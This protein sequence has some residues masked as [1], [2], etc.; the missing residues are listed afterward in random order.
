[1]KQPEA[2]RAIRSETQQMDTKQYDYIIVGAG[3]AGCV[4]A[5]RLSADARTRVLLLE[6]GPPDSKL[7]I[8]IPAGMTRL[9]SDPGVNWRY[10][11]SSE[12]GLNGRMLACPRGKT[13]GGSS[14]INGL[15]YMRG[16]PDDYNHWRELGNAGWGWDDVLPFYRRSECYEGGSTAYHGADGELSVENLKAPHIAS[17]AFVEAGQRI[18]VP[19]NTD[20][21]GA[22]HEGIG[23]LQL[24]LRQG[25]RE[26]AS[27]AFLTPAKHRPN[28]DVQVN[29]H[30]LKV[31]TEGRVATG[32]VYRQGGVEQRALA[33]EVILSG[34]AI[35]SPQL[36]M[37]SGIGPAQQLRGFGID[38][39]HDL[40]GVG[41]NLH[42]HTYVHY[43]AEVSPEFSINRKISSNLRV[44][45]HV[46]RYVLT[47]SGLL[48][49]AAAQVGAYL[50]SRPGLTR[51]DLQLQFRP[52]SILVRKDGR[53]TAENVPAV[54]ASCSQSRPKSRGRL[55]LAAAD[56]FAPPQILF[57]YLTDSEDCRV[58]MSGV[59]W[60]RRMFA[61]SP[62]V[63]HVVKETVPGGGVDSDDELLAYLRANAQPMYHPVGS[64]KMGRDGMS[65]VDE[66]LRVHGIERLRVVDASVMPAITS[67]NTNAPTI[68]IAE[69]ASQMILE[70]AHG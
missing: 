47:R 27:S 7:W 25:V 12:P 37:L 69:K 14:S 45:P 18:G 64:C 36:L 5:N 59:R 35:N 34:G 3:S 53:I 6:A 9:I 54:T 49:S 66:R 42:D 17:R 16:H 44:L 68:M 52:F 67:G 57:N 51:P 60:M 65:V 46:L 70:D 13:L 23:F 50:R 28:L 4:L 48:T 63:E 56:P 41:E 58:L 24:N 2:W 8:R 15:V 1:M 39:V 61:A 22:T 21:G 38:V 31:L 29:A 43:L 33:G 30:V 11:T 26:S 10:T 40:A 62:F 32:V 55:S 19:L 20:F